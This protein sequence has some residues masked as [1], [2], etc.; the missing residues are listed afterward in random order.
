MFTTWFSTDH[1]LQKSLLK[2]L[3]IHK[4]FQVK[5]QFSHLT[6]KLHKNKEKKFWTSFLLAH[7]YLFY[8]LFFFVI[9]IFE[10]FLKFILIWKPS[11]ALKT[12]NQ[13]DTW[14]VS[15]INYCA[16]PP[17]PNWNVILCDTHWLALLLLHGNEQDL[18]NTGGLYLSYLWGM[19]H[20]RQSCQA[21]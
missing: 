20:T 8:F 21:N 13:M 6:F 1:S 15:T 2:L 5:I 9:N 7:S 4:I 19:L 12:F 3:V 18:R 11:F 16:L 17:P 10:E 14:P